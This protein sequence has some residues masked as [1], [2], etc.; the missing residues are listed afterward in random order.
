ME[1]FQLGKWNTY[2]QPT[3]MSKNNSTLITSPYII[4]FLRLLPCQHAAQDLRKGCSQVWEGHQGGH[5]GRQE[6]E[7]GQEEGIVC[8]LHLQGKL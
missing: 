8:H 5:Q 2:K 7:E 1:E 6:E 4:L 3:I